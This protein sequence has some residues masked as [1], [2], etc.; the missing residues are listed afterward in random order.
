MQAHYILP[1][2]VFKVTNV[3]CCCNYYHQSYVMYLVFG[4]YIY[5]DRIIPLTL[6]S[7]Q[8]VHY[9]NTLKMNMEAFYVQELCPISKTS[10][11]YATRSLV[12]G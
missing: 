2:K 10:Q 11:S 4:P 6:W 5:F 1:L 3:L 7:I 9:L 12:I 8:Q